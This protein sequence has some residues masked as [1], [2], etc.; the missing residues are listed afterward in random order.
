MACLSEHFILFDSLVGATILIVAVSYLFR[1]FFD[2]ISRIGFRLG[3]S[4]RRIKVQRVERE[5]ELVE[6]VG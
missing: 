6:P 1:P 4:G 5:R 2:G 3:G